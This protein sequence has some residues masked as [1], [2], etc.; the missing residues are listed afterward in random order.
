M[1][2]NNRTKPKDLSK[3]IKYLID[4]LDTNLK[5]L[6]IN[7]KSKYNQFQTGN[8][9]E[10]IKN[11]LKK[12]K[13]TSNCFLINLKDLSNKNVVKPQL[14]LQT[15]QDKVEKNIVSDNNVLL[16]QPKFWAK[17]ITVVL[18]SGTGFGIAWLALAKTDEVVL[19]RGILEPIGGV[20]EVQMPLAGVAKEILVS[21]GEQV[22]KGQVLIRLDTDISEAENE[23]IKKSISINE[24]ILNKLR[25]LSSEGAVSEI[26]VL[27][28]ET[29]VIELRTQLKTNL[30]KLRYQEIISPI[31]GMVFELDPKSPGYVAQ[32]S[33]P[34]LKIVPI[35]N[36]QA[37][38]EIENRTIGFVKEGKTAEIS[39]DSFP[40]S[41]FGV[42]QGKVISISSDALVPKPSEG[43]GYRFPAKISLDNQHLLLKSGKKLPL[44]AGM[45]LTANIKL[46]KISYLKLLL[47]K[48]SDKADSLKSI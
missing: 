29:K 28:Q 6:I 23:A 39:I 24:D 45:S 32:T 16:K 34:V 37:K 36:L 42:I 47:N 2:K 26:Q 22:V 19:A 7:S 20:V 43:K 14:I 1:K 40:G 35:K 31:N 17:A 11:L 30:V 27:Q 9:I 44:Q 18:M 46:R 3:N 13:S 15:I 33:E 25:F 12:L 21:E 8:D 38:V 48:F 41:D 5:S 10:N 4:K